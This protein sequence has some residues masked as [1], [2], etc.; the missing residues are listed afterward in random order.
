MSRLRGTGYG[1]NTGYGVLKTGHFPAGKWHRGAW[2]FA[3]QKVVK[4][5]DTRFAV[6]FVY[7]LVVVFRDYDH[8]HMK[9]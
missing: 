1:G 5:P 2:H 9:C 4:P 6:G 7:A 8:Q 3:A